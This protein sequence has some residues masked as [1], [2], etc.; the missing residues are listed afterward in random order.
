M[1][2]WKVV[3]GDARFT[4]YVF[5][6]GAH[7]SADK[8]VQNMFDDGI[9]HTME[10]IIARY[11]EVVREYET[12]VRTWGA[13]TLFEP[14]VNKTVEIARAN[15]KG[16]TFAVI[17]GDGANTDTSETVSAVRR[18]SR[19]PCSFAFVGIPFKGANWGLLE[20]L[21]DMWWRRF[22]NWQTVLLEKYTYETM[23]SQFG[24]DCVGELLKQV[25]A[26]RAQ[27][28]KAAARL[29]FFVMFLVL[30]I[31]AAAAAVYLLGPEDAIALARIQ[32]K[33]V[34][35]AAVWWAQVAKAGVEGVI[36]PSIA[37]RFEL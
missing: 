20:H 6:N 9:E 36:M 14:L 13:Y 1:C 26:S 18:A 15:P 11:Q 24:L 5:G 21:D 29:R 22:D 27:R 25:Q 16:F 3:D 33:V 31:I 19:F 4:S 7:Q 2:L 10:Q 28:A 32:Y 17:I 34:S 23:G 12:G 8:Y 30:L 35:S 37:K